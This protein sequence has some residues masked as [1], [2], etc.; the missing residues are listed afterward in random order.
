[1]ETL[2]IDIA[3]NGGPAV[4]TIIITM[5]FLKNEIKELKQSLKENNAVT[6]QN[7]LSIV[8][9]EGKL[10]GMNRVVEQV[11]KMQKDIDEAFSRVRKVESRDI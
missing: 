4:I 9:L 2:L 11:P 1:M 6:Q 5:L 3:K 8:R 10:E 7:T